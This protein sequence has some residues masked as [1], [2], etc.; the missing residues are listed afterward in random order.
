MC[1]TFQAVLYVKSFY[2]VSITIFCCLGLLVSYLVPNVL[3]LSSLCGSCHP[4]SGECSCKPGWSGLYCNE[5]CSP[6]FYGESCQQICSCQNG[7]DCDSVRGKCIC[8]PGFKGSDCSIPCPLGT[9]GANCS[10]TCNCK[11]EAICSPVDGSCTCK[12]GKIKNYFL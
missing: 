6:G 9:Y 3:F 4:M 2:N 10:S 8:A 12:A 5:T 1:N 11:N 7:A